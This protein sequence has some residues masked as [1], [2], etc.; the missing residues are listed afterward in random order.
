MDALNTIKMSKAV[1]EGPWPFSTRWSQKYLSEGDMLVQM[2]VQG[3]TLISTL[4]LVLGP[5]GH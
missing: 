4:T 3:V 5:C 2:F 1:E